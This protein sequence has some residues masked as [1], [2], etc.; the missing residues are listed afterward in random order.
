M[1]H[2]EMDR[3]ATLATPKTFE[4]SFGWG[5][6]KRPGLFI[7]KRTK[8]QQ[9]HSPFSERHKISDNI[10]YMGSIGNP[11]YGGLVDHV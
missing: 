9:V 7:V 1:F 6:G 10:L 8:P 4:Y 5:Y 11:V 3:I 2:D